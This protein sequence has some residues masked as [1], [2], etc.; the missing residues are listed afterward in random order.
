MV[1]YPTSTTKS[2]RWGV[3][4]NAYRGKP[5]PAITAW[6]TFCRHFSINLTRTPIRNTQPEP[7]YYQ[8]RCRVWRFE[9]ARLNELMA[10]CE[11]GR[12]RLRDTKLPEF[13]STA[14]EPVPLLNLLLALSSG[15]NAVPRNV[16]PMAR[17]D[18][19]SGFV[20]SGPKPRRY[21]A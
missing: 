11:R 21:N 18:G 12:A 1:F 16:L 2:L 5:K 15:A 17:W 20:A 19:V 9:G 14:A 3:N 4:G 13:S 10:C 6:Q 7:K 8:L